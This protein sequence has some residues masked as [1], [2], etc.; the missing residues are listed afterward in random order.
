MKIKILVLIFSVIPYAS[1]ANGK[2][3]ELVKN[4]QIQKDK[5]KFVKGQIRKS[6][7][8]RLHYQSLLFKE[9]QKSELSKNRHEL[10]I[11]K[12]NARFYKEEFYKASNNLAKHNSDLNDLDGCY[13]PYQ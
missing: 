13:N 5:I 7:L 4:I 8:D 3:S 2:C 6:E 9:L 11:A 10:H 12:N 1:F